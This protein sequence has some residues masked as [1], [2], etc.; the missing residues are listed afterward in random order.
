VDFGSIAA[1]DTASVSGR[2]NVE[3]DEIEVQQGHLGQYRVEPLSPVDIRVFQDNR[4]DDRYANADQQ[5]RITR[6][7]PP[8]AS[9][10]YV[11]GPGTPYFEVDNPNPYALDHA[12][13]A[14]AGFKIILE[15]GTLSEDQVQGTP[16]SV[17]VDKLERRA[18]QN[19][20]GR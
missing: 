14:F 13:V 15:S 6:D 20:P 12:Y 9:E 5:G 16:R 10:V 17:P 2:S 11:L 19:D 8:N 18:Q 4:R 3:V 1:N 7:L